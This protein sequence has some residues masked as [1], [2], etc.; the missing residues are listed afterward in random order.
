VPWRQARNGVGGPGVLRSRRRTSTT[1]R[2]ALP[3]MS[4]R[5]PRFSWYALLLVGA[6]AALACQGPP[7]NQTFVP[8]IPTLEGFKDIPPP[9]A[10]QDA[11]GPVVS[12]A[13]EIHCGTLDCHGS[14]V[15]NLRIYGIDG[16][17]APGLVPGGDP[18]TDE[19]QPGAHAPFEHQLTYESLIA[20]QPE[21]LSAIVSQHGARPERWMIITKGRGSEHHKGGSRMKS[22]DDTDHCIISWLTGSVDKDACTRSHDAV[23]PPDY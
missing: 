22:G 21:V 13:L 15:R 5:P 6:Y 14:S 16:I 11:T 4:A 10:P 1:T 3:P 23:S 7:G 9:P 2:G 18:T 19:A 20:I 8:T 12:D 17:R